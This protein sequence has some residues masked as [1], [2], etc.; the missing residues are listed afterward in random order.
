MINRIEIIANT[1]KDKKT[2]AAAIGFLASLQDSKYQPLFKKYINDS[3]YTVAGAALGGIDRIRT[4]KS[5]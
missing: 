5:L 1:D 2:K 4:G 3:S